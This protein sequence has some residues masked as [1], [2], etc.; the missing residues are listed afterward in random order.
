VTV[1]DGLRRV[2]NCAAL[3]HYLS[4]VRIEPYAAPSAAALGG[5]ADL[6][7]QMETIIRAA[8]ESLSAEALGGTLRFER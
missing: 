3:L 7:E 2:E 4:D 5:L 1:E 8:R 6:C